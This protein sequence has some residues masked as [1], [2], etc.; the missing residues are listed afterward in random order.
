MLTTA[1]EIWSAIGSS[2]SLS[3]KWRRLALG[4]TD[5]LNEICG[6]ML[7]DQ[8]SGTLNPTIGRS[9]EKFLGNSSKK[10]T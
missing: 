2:S 9:I 7:R 4:S 6:M 1:K 8:L 3:T 5:T 10:T